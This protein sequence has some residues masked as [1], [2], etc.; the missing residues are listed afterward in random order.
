MNRV[1]AGILDKV[2]KLP[3]SVI[4]G[5]IN[6]HHT[7]GYEDRAL[8][9]GQWLEE[10]K[11]FF[12]QSLGASADISLAVLDSSHWLQV[13]ERIPYGVPWA[14]WGYVVFLPA[15]IDDGAMVSHLLDKSDKVS[16][17]VLDKLE[18]HNLT[19]DEA[20]RMMIDIAGFHELGHIYNRTYGLTTHR[21]WFDEITASYFARAHMDHMDAEHPEWVAVSE[22]M[23]QPSIDTVDPAYTSFED[24]ENI[25][26][27][28]EKVCKGNYG[29]YQAMF[30]KRVSA[31][32]PEHGL[33]FIEK[34]KASLESDRKLTDEELLVRLEEIAPGFIQWAEEVENWSFSARQ[35]TRDLGEH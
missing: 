35:A 17:S 26:M 9:L 6:V 11:E 13:T 21:K 3:V 8:M 1:N 30:G 27:D 28:V 15:T 32:Y 31:M 5:R 18:S 19:Y 34:A 24:F 20:A 22:G 4:E 12:E 2:K 14:D 29:W 25:Y 23:N 10:A 16:Q 33:S 7:E